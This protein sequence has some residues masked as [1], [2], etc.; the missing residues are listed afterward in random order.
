MTSLRV[1]LRNIPLLLSRQKHGDF[2][3]LKLMVSDTG[4]S[5][6]FRVSVSRETPFFFLFSSLLEPL[7][8]L[9]GLWSTKV[10][11]IFI[12]L[13]YIFHFRKEILTLRHVHWPQSTLINDNYKADKEREERRNVFTNPETPD[14]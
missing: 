10:S 9:H 6:S 2:P 7:D 11:Y 14:P 4:C 5:L 13:S 1:V 12:I 8:A 3:F